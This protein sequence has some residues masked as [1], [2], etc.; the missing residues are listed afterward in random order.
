MHLYYLPI[1]LL[2]YRY[3]YRGFVLS[4][5]LSLAY[6]VL[7]LFYSTGQNEVVIG[8][9]IRF[10]VFIGIAAVVAYLSESFTQ[11]EKSLKKLVDIQESS[12]MNA[13]VWLVLLDRRGSVLLWNNAAE[14]I[15][16]YSAAEVTGSHTI[17][18][19]LYPDKGYRAEITKKIERI[20]AEDHFF[21]NLETTIRTKSG[22]EKVIS[23]N[24][25]SFPVTSEQEARSIAIGID[26]TE[27]KRTQDQLV[28]SERKF[29]AAFQAS[30]DPIAITEIKTGKILD[31]NQAFENWSGY[32]R[33]EMTGKTTRDLNLWV[34]PEERDSF[35]GILNTQG[36]VHKI[37]VTL[38]TK[39]GDLR[40]I[41]F[42]AKVLETGNNDYML[43]L[44]EDI[45][46]R[47]VADETLRLANERFKHYVNANIVGI[48]LA[49]PSGSIVDANDYYLH[50]L[51]Y[52]REEFEQ[53]K[54]NWRTL[55]PPEWL[56]TDEHALEELRS[57]G[58]CTPYEKE[59]I[60]KDGTR[61]AVLISDAMLPGPQE[62]IAAFILDITERKRVKDALLRV[63]QKLNVISQL[64]RK[65]LAN[66][67]FVLNSYLEL[68]KNQL[69]GHDR[70]IETV[71]KG[72]RA[73]QSIHET[74]E[75]SKDYQDMGEKPPKWQNMK[76]AFLFGLS[77]ISIGNILHSLETENLEIFADPLLEKV[78]QRLF[79]NSVKHGEHVTR[80]R[81][82]HTV[83][84]EGAT[85]FFEDDGI[86]I[87]KERKEQIF[88]R[89]EGTRVS[90]RS[91]IFAREILD[92]TGIT[93][94][95]TGEPGKGVR[96]EMTV[97]KGAWRITG[98]DTNHVNGKTP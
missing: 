26:I 47:K 70:A 21:E 4:V 28:F 98:T 50:M 49:T 11:S 65:D 74:I 64:T 79:E 59:Y 15:S 55:T 40:N 63:N 56:H 61:V 52:T 69:A 46:E 87:S 37:E 58:K 88:L 94:R 2:A 53:G 80:I 93:I 34:Y 77:H 95:E 32:L 54:V 43:S 30:P 18:K 17:W 41:L 36:F 85:I 90:M 66:Q 5:I 38:R 78:C 83:T 13:N 91:L 39:R 20:I 42:S 12:L 25:R 3:R 86:G 60:R 10:V 89:S 31:I 29:A 96:F 8:A 22:D 6:I 68:A 24:T 7:V 23:W 9:M 35:V 62:Q 44:A 27:R 14:R 84:P 97:P 67:I 1:V 73:I 33:Q 51:G 71:Q 19:L 16:G 45:T 92:I 76:M 57:R 75:Y 82:W 81:I 48:I 72:V